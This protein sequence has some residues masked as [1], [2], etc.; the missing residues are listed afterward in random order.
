MITV[1]LWLPIVLVW[2][3]DVAPLPAAQLV[4]TAVLPMLAAR[5]LAAQHV[6]TAVCQS[7]Q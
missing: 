1:K 3:A 6:L 7:L 4:V 2:V 5:Q